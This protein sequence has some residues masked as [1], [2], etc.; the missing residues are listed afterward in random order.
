LQIVISQAEPIKYALQRRG[1]ES[2][3]EWNQYYMPLMPVPWCP[4][5]RS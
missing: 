2:V 5:A 4:S 3:C 1:P